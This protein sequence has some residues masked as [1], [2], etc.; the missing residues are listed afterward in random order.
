VIV[1]AAVFRE[2]D[3]DLDIVLTAKIR[4]PDLHETIIGAVS[5]TGHL[6]ADHRMR[7]ADLSIE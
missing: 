1:G 2:L 5:E 6:Y 3:A 7:P 4:S